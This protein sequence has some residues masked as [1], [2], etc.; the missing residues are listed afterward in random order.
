M[1]EHW[2]ERAGARLFVAELGLGTPVVL[3]HGGLASHQAVLRFAAPLADRM[4]IIAPDLRAS[5]RSIWRA[6]IEWDLLADDIAAIADALEIERAIV[7]G[8]S[9]GA[10]CAVRVALRHPRLVAGLLVLNPAYGGAEL[11][12]TS[13]QAAAMNAMAAAGREALVNGMGAFDPLLEGLPAEMRE[14]ARAVVRGYDAESVAAT[15][16]F[17]ASGLQPFGRAEELAAIGCPAL[18]VPGVDPTHPR[19]VAEVF[20]KGIAGAEVVE[21]ADYAG[22]IAGF[23]GRRGV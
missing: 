17:M 1:K 23:V 18:V 7:G 9:F 3:I 22:A 21:T 8:T 11:G 6:P 16:A 4:R 13:A 15:T 12:F 10:G 20:A 5:G 19:E 2:V 14:A